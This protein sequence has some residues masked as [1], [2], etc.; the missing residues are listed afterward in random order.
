MKDKTDRCGG[1]PPPG[2]TALQAKKAAGEAARAASEGTQLALEAVEASVQHFV[3]VR[4]YSRLKDMAE[5]S[6]VAGQVHALQFSWQVLLSLPP[7]DPAR[8]WRQAA[9]VYEAA[10]PPQGEANLLTLGE[11]CS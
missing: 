3:A 8:S 11:G 7:S 2:C 9:H 1:F 5:A 4:D 10:H 6:A